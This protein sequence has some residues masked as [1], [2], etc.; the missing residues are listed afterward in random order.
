MTVGKLRREVDDLVGVLA[1]IG[2]LVKS[3]ATAIEARPPLKWITWAGRTGR[4]P[5]GGET[6]S[7]YR[8]IL[9]N[10]EYTCVLADGA[11]LQI[12]LALRGADLERH[13]FAWI[14]APVVV[15][16]ADVNITDVAELVDEGLF[17]AGV[18]LTD[19]ETDGDDLL[20][21]APL[22][23]D[24]DRSAQS[25]DHAACHLTFNRQSC[26]VPIFGPLSLGHFIR[27]VFRHFYPEY[28]KS[29]ERLRE[30]SLRFGPRLIT[31]IQEGEI[32]MDCRQ[33][34]GFMSRFV[35]GHWSRR[36]TVKLTPIG[37]AS[38]PRR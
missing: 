14:P 35:S 24:Y 18:K 30:W 5:L 37:Q 28:W 27:F 3:N 31:Q 25:D 19:D 34:G 1:S 38:S 26:R 20:L 10:R 13:R 11:I 36:G 22:R 32:F 12:S 4:L 33:S 2:L 7:E 21:I 9:R 16:S 17:N 6:V 8:S 29:S 15:D 23:F